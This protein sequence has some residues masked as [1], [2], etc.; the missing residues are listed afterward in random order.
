MLAVFLFV[1]ILSIVIIFLYVSVY[2]VYCC[3]IGHVNSAYLMLYLNL[4]LRSIFNYVS[5]ILN[6]HNLEYVSICL[7][8]RILNYV[9]LFS[10]VIHL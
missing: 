1:T 8:I 2:I 3:Y 9:S 4:S 7:N 5:I 10:T 6:V